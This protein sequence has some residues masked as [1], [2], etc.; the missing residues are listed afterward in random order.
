MSI[1]HDVQ[2]SIRCRHVDTYAIGHS[3]HVKCVC[4]HGKT[5][6]DDHVA[7]NIEGD[8]GYRLVDTHPIRRRIDNQC[9]RIHGKI[10][11]E[12]GIRGVHVST[13]THTTRDHERSGGFGCG[14]DHTLDVHV[15]V[16]I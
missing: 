8:G 2:R 12:Y 7:D 15:T 4:I 11:R 1:T 9:V 14:T 5:I 6:G 10:T 3:I 16:H 13:D